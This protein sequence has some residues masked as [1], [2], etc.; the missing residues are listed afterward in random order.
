MFVENV[1]TSGH[2][3]RIVALDY[4]LEAQEKISKEIKLRIKGNEWD[5]KQF[6]L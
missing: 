5:R 3:A 4:S 1:V 6:H 2:Q